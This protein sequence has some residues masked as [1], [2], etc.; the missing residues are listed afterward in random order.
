MTATYLGNLPT[1]LSHL[2]WHRLVQGD[3]TFSPLEPSP[4][5]PPFQ[6]SPLKP[7]PIPPHFLPS[8]PA[9]APALA[10]PRVK[11]V[12]TNTNLDELD[13]QVN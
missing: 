2:L 9:L 8:P 12:S 13:Q 1:R 4:V 7:S 6:P 11:A 10:P 5:P 3:T